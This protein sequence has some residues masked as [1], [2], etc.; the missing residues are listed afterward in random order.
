MYIVVGLGNPGKKY[1]QTRHNVG[2]NAIDYLSNQWNITV[3]KSKHKA[4]IG[5]KNLNGEK[6]ILVKPQTFMN[7]SGQAVLELQR[8]YKVPIENI[9]VVYD[10]LDLEVGKLR[11]R[12]NGSAGTHNGMKSILQL[13][14][15]KQFPRIRI[16]IGKPR[17]K[18]DII[19]HVLGEFSKD[20]RKIIN[21]IVEITQKAIEEII[22]GD[23][24]K[25]MNQYN[26]K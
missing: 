19:N 1:E 21:E 16:G 22:L 20:D 6:V 24:A 3:N 17:T 12:P 2:F 14:Q 7:E 15:D 5:E 8:Y 23:T 11:I 9:I 25:A 13:I 26:I 4:L 18:G 10:D